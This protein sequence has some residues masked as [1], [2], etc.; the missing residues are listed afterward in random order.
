MRG[1]ATTR[2][3]RLTSTALPGGPAP[4]WALPPL[5]CFESVNSES[6]SAHAN[7]GSGGG[8]AVQ[9]APAGAAQVHCQDRL[10]CG[11][12]RAREG[13]RLL[14]GVW[15]RVRRQLPQRL[16]GLPQVHSQGVHRLRRSRALLFAGV[17]SGSSVPYG[18]ARLR[19]ACRVAGG[20]G[21]RS[22]LRWF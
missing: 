21:Y 8:G 13:G 4:V 22:L 1:G 19:R 14:R 16:Q 2:A 6:K 5:V 7:G 9:G 18:P 3:T 12:G 10:W 15:H 20:Y 11:A 17:S